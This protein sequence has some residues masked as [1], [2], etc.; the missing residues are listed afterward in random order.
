MPYTLNLFCILSTR[1]SNLLQ[2]CVLML[3]MLMIPCF[4]ILMWSTTRSFWKCGLNYCD[5][6]GN[7]FVWNINNISF[8]LWDWNG[9]QC[10]CHTIDK[11]PPPLTQS[12]EALRTK[13]IYHV[14]IVVVDGANPPESK[15]PMRR[16]RD[17]KI[18]FVN[19]LE[20]FNW[21]QKMENE[22]KDSVWTILNAW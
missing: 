19:C 3:I 17:L 10:Y 22:I 9:R 6:C 12:V 13:K 14:K 8:L 11:S 1:W 18:Y 15:T 21:S 4:T 7:V 20:V 2:I 5:I 16:S